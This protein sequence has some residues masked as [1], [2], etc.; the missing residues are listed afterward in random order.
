MSK[1]EARKVKRKSVK[2][3]DFSVEP[4]LEIILIKG[5]QLRSA[6]IT[7]FSD[8]YVVFSNG[9][10]SVQSKIKY[11]TLNPKWNETLLLPVKKDDRVLELTV[12]DWDPF[13]S[14]IYFLKFRS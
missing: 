11:Q 14:L 9:G 10:T 12:N 8:P 7:G 3:I 2:E 5:N 1:E 4:Y 6:D 13:K